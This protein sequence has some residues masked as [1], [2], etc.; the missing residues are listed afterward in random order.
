MSNVYFSCPE[1]TVLLVMEGA[2][3]VKAAPIVRKF[4]GQTIGALTCWARSKFGGPIIV[5]K[6][7]EADCSLGHRNRQPDRGQPVQ[8]ARGDAR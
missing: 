1:F 4:E 3:I 2:V 5:E 8:E 6:L 7:S